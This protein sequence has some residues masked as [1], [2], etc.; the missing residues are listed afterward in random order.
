[1]AP[2]RARSSTTH[3]AV[4]SETSGMMRSAAS[5]RWNCTSL[6]LI[7]GYCL[8]SRVAR[9]RISAKPSMPAKPPPTTTKVSRRCR[10]SPRGSPAARS[11]FVIILFR[12]HTASSTAFRP[13]ALSAMP[14][15]GNVRDTA[16]IV[17]TRMS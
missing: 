1:M 12:I 17:T 5:M 3:L 8:S 10:S 16:P 2:R 6:G 4:S 14:G 15:I 11:K 9:P 7:S 13:M